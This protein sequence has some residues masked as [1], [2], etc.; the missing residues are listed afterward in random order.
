VQK[1][2]HK[3]LV[4][5]VVVAVVLE[6]LD[7]DINVHLQVLLHPKVLAQTHLFILR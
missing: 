2:V 4:L 7:K 1:V 6:L 5:L 3:V